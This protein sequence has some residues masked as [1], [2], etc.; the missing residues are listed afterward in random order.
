MKKKKCSFGCSEVAYLGHVI[1]AV[2][3]AMDD[4]KVWAVVEWLVPRSV[5][6]VCA[7]PGFVGYYRHT[8][9]H[10]ASQ[11]WLSLECRG[12]GCIPGPRAHPHYNVGVAIARLQ[13]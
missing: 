13:A 6:A 4:Q 11:G 1:S 3:V 9:H 7:F 10:P 8:T 12:R 2:G 5:R